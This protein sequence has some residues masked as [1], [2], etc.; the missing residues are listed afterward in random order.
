MAIDKTRQSQIKVS[1][2]CI[3]TLNSSSAFFN[4]LE[5]NLENIC[6]LSN[7]I[8]IFIII[9]FRWRCK[10][11]LWSSREHAMK[12]F[13]LPFVLHLSSL[14][15]HFLDTISPRYW[16][17]TS[18]PFFFDCSLQHLLLNTFRSHNNVPKIVEFSFHDSPSDGHVCSNLF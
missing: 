9:N 15:R 6:T 2:N 18:T 10:E 11:L 8:L 13:H 5:I 1:W 14:S 4:N 17:T 16:W 7:D 12:L 3:A